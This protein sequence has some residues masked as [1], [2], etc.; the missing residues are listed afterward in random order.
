MPARSTGH[1]TSVPAAWLGRPTRSCDRDPLLPPP[2][3]VLPTSGTQFR[4]EVRRSCSGSHWVSRTQLPSGSRII[5]G[6]S[7][8]EGN[9]A[10]PAHACRG[11]L[12]Q[13]Q[14]QARVWVVNGMT[15]ICPRSGGC[16]FGKNL[17]LWRIKRRA[18]PL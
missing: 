1:G 17:V 16:G 15:G 13:D 18:G 6:V 8:R 2:L 12:L 11:A 14:D 5:S 10:I 4:A 9:A 3:Q 7:G